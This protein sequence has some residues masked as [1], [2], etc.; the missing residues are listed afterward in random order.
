MNILNLPERHF[1]GITIRTHNDPGPNDPNASITDLWM[2]F[3]SKVSPLIQKDVCYGIYTDYESDNTGAYSVSATVE[4]DSPDDAPDG[5]DVKT[6][7]AGSYMRFSNKG[8][9]PEV[10][11]Q[12]WME[13]WNYFGKQGCP[14]ERAYLGDIEEYPSDKEV[15]IYVGLK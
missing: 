11:A 10:V 3:G 14:H 9:M 5:L 13:I 2:S 7:P 8:T 15:I 6:T 12:T 4:V 1:T